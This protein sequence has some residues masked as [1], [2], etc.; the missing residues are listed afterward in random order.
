MFIHRIDMK[1]GIS[2]LLNVPIGFHKE[3]DCE[4]YLGRF[5]T[6][7]YFNLEFRVFDPEPKTHFAR[8]RYP[9]PEMP[10]E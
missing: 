3:Y 8:Y 7:E 1:I 2:E 5:P 10:I 6:L 4:N 9:P